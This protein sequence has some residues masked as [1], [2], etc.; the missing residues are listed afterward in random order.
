VTSFQELREQ[1]EAL[2]TLLPDWDSY[3]A[4]VPNE[5]SLTTCKDILHLLET[6]HKLEADKV[7]ADVDGG[8][9][10][11]WKDMVF[12]KGR[13]AYIGC[14]NDKTVWVTL[15]NANIPTTDPGWFKF[16]YVSEL[17]EVNED[18]TNYL[19]LDIDESIE[20]IRH[21]IWA[22]FRS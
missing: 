5:W 22:D 1:L 20:L 15:S 12:N 17:T 3:G 21:F 7:V 4:E 2:R 9:A 13:N 10:I 19:F 8:V 11:F 6:D 18:I 16:W 14:L